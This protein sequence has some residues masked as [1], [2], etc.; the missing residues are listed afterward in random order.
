MDRLV[1][2]ESLVVYRRVFDPCGLTTNGELWDCGA[3]MFALKCLWLARKF[4]IVHVH[5]LDE[6]VPF[7]KFFYP[8]K[9]LVLHYHGS[10]IRGK[11]GL[12]RK[13]WS[14][15]DV[16]LYS[17]LDLL[18]D[19]TPGCAVYLPN[20]VDIEIFYPKG[21]KPKPKAAFHFSY[22]ADDLAMEYAEKYGLELT[23]YNSKKQ[24]FIPHLRFPEVLCQYRYY[25]DVK[26]NASGELLTVPLSKT[27]LEALACGLKVITWKGEIVESLPEEHLPEKVLRRLYHLYLRLKE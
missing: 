8:R 13:Y 24:G 2:T 20:P 22:N 26:R 19:K 7:L 9:P 25:I 12:R 11:W 6:L 23:I 10:R 21:V 1:G 4:D 5:F 27:A 3:K 15:A 17:T 16:V 18:D 14:K